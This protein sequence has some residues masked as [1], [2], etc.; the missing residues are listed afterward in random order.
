MMTGGYAFYGQPIGVLLLDARYPR[1]PG[2]VGHAR[3]YTWGVQ[4]EVVRGLTADRLIHHFDHVIVGLVHE[5]IQRLAER[6]ARV[7]V[8]G[9]G[10]FARVHRE[11]RDTSAIPFLS[12]SLVQVPWLRMIYGD[13]I[14][15][16]TIDE[17]ALDDQ[18]LADLGWSRNDPIVV[19]GVDPGSIFARVYFENRDRFEPAAMQESVVAAARQLVKR[20][21]SVRAV[22][23]E[24]TN[25][26]P[27]AWAVQEVLPVP[28]FDIQGLAHYASQALMRS[29]YAT[30]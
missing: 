7:V 14:G 30:T 6:G 18:Y 25:M 4:F 3:T 8:G 28:I 22:V 29:P 9:C 26:A 13:P 11:I 20:E 2:D 21:P 17:A 12:S 23:L 27:F 1:I 16:L 15:V 5:A 24:C 10:F 19:Q